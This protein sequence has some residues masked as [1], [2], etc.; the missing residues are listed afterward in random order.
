MGDAV[1]EHAN[2]R[3]RGGLPRHRAL[4][5]NDVVGGAWNDAAVRARGRA[6]DRG[7]AFC[8]RDERARASR[9]LLPAGGVRADLPETCE[10]DVRRV[11]DSRDR[12]RHVQAG[13]HRRGADSDVP[14]ARSAAVRVAAAAVRVRTRQAAD[15]HP[16]GIGRAAGPDRSRCDA[17][18]DRRELERRRSRVPPAAPAVPAVLELPS[19]LNTVHEGR[20]LY[21]AVHPNNP[22]RAARRSKM[23]VRSVAPLSVG[24]IAGV[25]YALIGLIVGAFFALAA[26][27][28]AFAGA[29]HAGIIGSIMGLG[30]IVVFPLLYGC[31]GFL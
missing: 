23:V 25:L 31:M 30:A 13:A 3:H 12:S 21:S 4:R 29:E 9:R 26:L 27:A 17:A 15:R 1:T 20:G 18:T 8:A 2:A 24:K 14:E 11:S 16:G 22:S 19:F 28:G 5:G 6:V 7:R 10:A